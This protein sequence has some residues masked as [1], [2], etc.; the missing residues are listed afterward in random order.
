MDFLGR[1]VIGL[2]LE[3]YSTEYDLYKVRLIYNDDYSSEWIYVD[4]ATFDKMH[5]DFNNEEAK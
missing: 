1:E 2:S 4:S 5:K 3:W